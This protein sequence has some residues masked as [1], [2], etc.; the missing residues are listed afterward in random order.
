[1]RCLNNYKPKRFQ[2]ESWNWNDTIIHV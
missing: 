2:R 1:M